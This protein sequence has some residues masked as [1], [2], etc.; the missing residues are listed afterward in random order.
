MSDMVIT[1]IPESVMGTLLS[2]AAE[3]NLSVEDYARQLVCDAAARA[4]LAKGQDISAAQLQDNLSAFLRI[5][6]YQPIFIIDELGRRFALISIT[7]F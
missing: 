2:G 5:A 1:N 3:S 4:I 6:E 7:E